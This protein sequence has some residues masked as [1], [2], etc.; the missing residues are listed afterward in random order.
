LPGGKTISYLQTYENSSFLDS[1]SS[2]I[3]CAP[4]SGDPAYG[5]CGRN[6]LR[7]PECTRSSIGAGPNASNNAFSD[8][9]TIAF[10]NTSLTY[11][12]H[13]VPV[14]EKP[15]RIIALHMAMTK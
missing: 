4:P 1:K 10:T 13:N 6:G 7:H 9:S 2:P 12:S 5:C 3:T 11:L 14:I 8:A 15:D